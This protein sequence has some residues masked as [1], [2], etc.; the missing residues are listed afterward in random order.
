M[1]LI[2]VRLNNNKMEMYH[3][4]S[5]GC[6]TLTGGGWIGWATEKKRSHPSST[7]NEFIMACLD[8][9]RSYH[10][11][12]DDQGIVITNMENGNVEVSTK[13]T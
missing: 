4:N 7:E 13:L 1:L 10:I 8:D 9:P 12:A 2:A 3:W 5:G 6:A 11:K